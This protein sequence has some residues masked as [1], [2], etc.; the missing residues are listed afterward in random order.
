[1]E[2]VFSKICPKQP[3]TEKTEKKKSKD[4]GETL[5]ETFPFRFFSFSGFSF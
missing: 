2:R 1:M 3:E 4:S 5:A